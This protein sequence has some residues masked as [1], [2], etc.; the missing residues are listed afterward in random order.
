MSSDF[1]FLIFIAVSILV[2]TMA[3]THIAFVILALCTGYVFSEFAGPSV[4]D[5]LQNWISPAEFPLLEVIQLALV[6]IP[7]I[8]I[9]I[10]F[11]RTQRGVGRF[12][13][14]LIP[15]LALTMLVTVFIVRIIPFSSADNLDQDSYLAGSIESFSP[16]LVIFAVGVA[17]F[18]VL[19]KHAN[20]PVRRKR[21]PGRPKK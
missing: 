1:L 10:R 9:G 2:L 7:A 18:D 12:V 14:Q 4:F 5:F 6:L 11:R 15:A 8:L 17:L 16:L 13:Q 21:G 20:E 19:I 3:K